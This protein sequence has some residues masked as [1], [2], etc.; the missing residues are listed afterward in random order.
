VLKDYSAMDNLFRGS[1]VIAIAI[2]IDEFQR[3]LEHGIARALFPQL[4]VAV[5]RRCFE[6][7]VA[8][9]IEML[10]LHRCDGSM[11]DTVANVRQSR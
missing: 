1:Q 8:G 2:T 3:V 11:Q 6:S 4:A 9:R 5:S 7:T 10:A